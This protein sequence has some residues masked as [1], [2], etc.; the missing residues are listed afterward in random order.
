MAEV[1]L[2]EHSNFRGREK[3]LY[4]SEPNLSAPDKHFFNDRVSSF[5]VVSGRWKVY[6]DSN[7]RGPAS[8][9]FGPGRYTW[10]EAAGIPNDSISSVRL[11][12]A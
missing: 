12:A 8:C 10:V 7:Y 5:V 6:R 4:G 2:S 9:V 3:H 11:M 1:V